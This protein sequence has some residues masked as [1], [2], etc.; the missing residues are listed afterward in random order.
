MNNL[1]KIFAAVIAIVTL[2][3]QTPAVQA[4][5]VAFFTAHPIFSTLVGGV[6][7]ILALIHQPDSPTK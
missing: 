3:V 5:L 6:S 1:T 7:A 2:V 4:A